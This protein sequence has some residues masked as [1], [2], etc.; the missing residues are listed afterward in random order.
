MSR[1]PSVVNAVSKKLQDKINRFIPEKVH[2]A[3]TKAIKEM[4][5]GVLFGSK[6]T[7]AKTETNIGIEQ[8]EARVLERITFYKR[9]A[10]AEGGITGAG[11]IVLAIADFPLLLTIK[12]KCFSILPAFMVLM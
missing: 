10:A 6:H 11:G 8:I 12:I 9:T 5:R 3:I 4:V 7:S 2:K 1:R